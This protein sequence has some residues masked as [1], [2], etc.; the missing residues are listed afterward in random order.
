MNLLQLDDDSDHDETEFQED[1]FKIEQSINETVPVTL[2]EVETV[3]AGEIFNDP[4]DIRSYLPELATDPYTHDILIVSES[5][6]PDRTFSGIL[7]DKWPT[8]GDVYIDKVRVLGIRSQS[9]Y[10]SY[11]ELCINGL[12]S[13]DIKKLWFLAQGL[14]GYIQSNSNIK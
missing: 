5:S 3:N 10:P 6:F 8:K 14:A 13:W 11:L 4:I 2:D 7:P 9:F 12:A 1:L